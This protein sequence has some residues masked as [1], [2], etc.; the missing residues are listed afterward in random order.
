MQRLGQPLPTSGDRLNLFR[1]GEEAGQV[2]GA[3]GLEVHGNA[4]LLRSVATSADHRS[5][6]VAAALVRDL[7]QDAR[8]YGL[9]SVS[10]LTTT[11]RPYFERLGLGSH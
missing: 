10:L 4:G 8:E 7:P 9:T 1:V 3:A 6:G 2:R 5:R 11:A